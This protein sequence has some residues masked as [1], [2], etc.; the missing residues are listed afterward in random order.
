MDGR[1]NR[2]NKFADLF[3]LFWGHVTSLYQA[4]PDGSNFKFLNKL[5]VMTKL[6]IMKT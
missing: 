1:P 6:P 2:K 3:V 5:K 4:F